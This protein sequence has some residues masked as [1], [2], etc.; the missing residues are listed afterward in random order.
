MPA[1]S[2]PVR[3]CKERITGKSRPRGV[4]DHADGLAFA[5]SWYLI[6]A[7][8]SV[9]RVA[10]S[11]GCAIRYECRPTR[12]QIA[13]IGMNVVA[14]RR[15]DEGIARQLHLEHHVVQATKRDLGADQIELP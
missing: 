2:I 9:T 5:E 14:R 1:D 12:T 11:R 3:L 7:T 15:Y 13:F 4:A 10:A 6:R 8:V